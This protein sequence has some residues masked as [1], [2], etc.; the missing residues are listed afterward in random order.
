MVLSVKEDW[1]ELLLNPIIQRISASWEPFF[2]EQ[3]LLPVA[4][5]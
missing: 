2:V 4:L 3:P 1:N 5:K